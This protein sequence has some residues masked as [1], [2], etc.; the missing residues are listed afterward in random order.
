ILCPAEI[1]LAQANNSTQVVGS[2]PY[3]I[4]EAVHSDHIKLVARKGWTWGPNNE[5][6]DAP[7]YPSSLTVRVVTDESTAANELLT[8]Q[9]D[10]ASTTGA[11]VP[12]LIAEKSLTHMTFGGQYLSNLVFN[13]S[14]PALQDQQVRKA[15]SQAIDTKAFMQAD[16]GGY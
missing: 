2:G 5:S 13:P 1:P 7:G 9:L 16:T 8:G 15:I 11:D 10:V 4:A 3:T 6:T 14:N 12:R